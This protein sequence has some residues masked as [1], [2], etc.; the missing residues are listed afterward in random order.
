MHV[1]KC[2]NHYYVSKVKK[3]RFSILRNELQDF[4]N[5]VFSLLS[6]I[7]EKMRNTHGHGDQLS[8]IH[9]FRGG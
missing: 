1:C 5:H 2:F 4:Q 6:R 9:L 3:L 8:I 7:G